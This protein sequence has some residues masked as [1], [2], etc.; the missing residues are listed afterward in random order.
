MD[1]HGLVLF[2]YYLVI[3]I[4]FK[5]CHRVQ[6]CIQQQPS[7]AQPGR[8]DGAP[9]SPKPWR[10]FG[11]SAPGVLVVVLVIKKMPIQHSNGSGMN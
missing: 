11:S 7:P 2:G 9:R 6:I 1:Y 3:Y 8:G 10:E 5:V 4:C